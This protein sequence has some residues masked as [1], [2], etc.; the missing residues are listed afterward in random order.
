ML[1]RGFC[2]TKKSIK[3]YFKRRQALVDTSDREGEG[4][5]V[6]AG[7]S[8]YNTNCGTEKVRVNVKSLAKRKEKKRRGK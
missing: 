7:M 2:T 4:K 5:K 6:T 3:R 1:L 8:I